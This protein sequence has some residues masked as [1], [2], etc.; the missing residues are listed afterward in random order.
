MLRDDLKTVA[1]IVARKHKVRAY[2]HETAGW[3]RPGVWHVEGPYARHQEASLP[4]SLLDAAH[5]IWRR[6]TIRAAV[7]RIAPPWRTRVLPADAASPGKSSIGYL[8]NE[9]KWKLFDLAARTVR[10]WIVDTTNLSRDID[11]LRRFDACFNIP[12]WQFVE[13][14]G[15]AWRLDDYIAGPNLAHCGP[16]ERIAIVRALLRQ[17]AE[18]ARSEGTPPDPELTRQAI[19]TMRDCA[20]ESIPARIAAKHGAGMHFLG[21]ALRLVP[22]HGD[23]SAQNVFVNDGAPWI[24]DWDNAGRRQPMFYDVIYLIMREA[25]LGRRDLVEAFLDGAFD[26]EVGEALRESGAA[27]FDLDRLMLLVHGY[28][29][30]FHGTRT[31]GHRDAVGENVDKLWEPLRAFCNDHV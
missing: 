16:E 30:H 28:T 27:H 1:D 7:Q 14:D 6:R 25:E 31:R 15:K 17:H 29:V 23:L 19:A 26:A 24:I 9:G 3:C 13:A 10:T 12:R 11:N 20:P 22:T 4:E 2:L 18:F 21:G 8:S 5:G